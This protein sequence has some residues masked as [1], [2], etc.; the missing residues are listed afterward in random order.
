M[1]YGLQI[2]STRSYSPSSR[3]PSSSPD[4]SCLA[5]WLRILPRCTETVQDV[6]LSS[7]VKPKADVLQVIASSRWRKSVLISNGKVALHP[8]TSVKVRDIHNVRTIL[9]P[10]IGFAFELRCKAPSE[11]TMRCCRN[12]VYNLSRR[13][14]EYSRTSSLS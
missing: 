5:D 11:L 4:T 3:L 13:Q 1:G 9:L 10:G 2:R 14:K 6:A 12:G 7:M 8:E